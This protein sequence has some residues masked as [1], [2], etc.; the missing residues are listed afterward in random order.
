MATETQFNPNVDLNKRLL[1]AGASKTVYALVTPE[2]ERAK[3][4]ALG[5]DNEADR[6]AFMNQFR[7]AWL[8][9]QDALHRDF[10]DEWHAWSAPVIKLNRDLFPHTYPTAGASEPLRQII[11]DFAAHGGKALHVFE[12]EYE[13]YKAM[14]EASGLEVIEHPRDKWQ[15]LPYE[16][17]EDALFFISQPSAIDG[18]VWRD[19]N[20]FMTIMPDRTVV[21]DVTYVG[22]VPRTAV[23]S[24]FNLNQESIR[25]VVFS[26]SKPFG[27]YYDRIGGV[28][29]REEDKGLF[30][31]MWFKS[32]T[33]IQ[34]GR[35][36]MRQNSVFAIPE[37]YASAQ[38]WMCRN[39]HK[40]LGINLIPSHVFILGVGSLEQSG[41]LVKYVSRAGR[42]RVCLTFGMAKMIGT[43]E[44]IEISD[45]E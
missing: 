29:S 44:D 27:A 45:V 13:G 43:A 38:I 5:Y 33:A 28:F 15:S 18:N 17:E 14:G 32:L 41:E 12:G 10:F 35:E 6:A 9:K 3:M 19:F 8:G 1:S 4:K 34:I 36:L 37:R 2:T 24:K 11:F 30:G 21:A 31:N 20:A 7:G 23:K 42:A 22:A 39:V 16:M 25:S 40:E 26:L